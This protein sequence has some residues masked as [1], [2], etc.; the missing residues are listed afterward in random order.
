MEMVLEQHE[1]EQLLREAL[2]A[3]GMK[4]P[5]E[6]V[7]VLRQNNKKGSFRL[8]F[9]APGLQRPPTGV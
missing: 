4:V 9:K 8:V 2:A 6:Q 1:V 3:R 7:L 5:E